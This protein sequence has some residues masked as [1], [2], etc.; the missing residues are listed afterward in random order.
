[1]TSLDNQ[2]PQINLPNN[3]PFKLNGSSS[4]QQP[5]FVGSPVLLR[6][7]Q[8]AAQANPAN[9]SSEMIRITNEEEE[10]ELSGTK[11]D[12]LRFIEKLLGDEDGDCQEDSATDEVANGAVLKLARKEGSFTDWR[13]SSPELLSFPEQ[14]PWT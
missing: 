10:N 1:M 3:F 4:G 8:Q 11:N 12:Q 13:L 9:L 2:N 14:S 5:Y 7:P 6:Q